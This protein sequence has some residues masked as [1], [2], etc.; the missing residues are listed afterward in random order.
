MTGESEKPKH[1]RGV[2]SICP[3]PERARAELLLAAGGRFSETAR[4]LGMSPDA[5]ERHW[6]KHVPPS[7][8]KALKPGAEALMARLE[9]SGQIAEESTGTLEHLKAVRA[10]L[11]Q[12]V[13]EA[14][15]RGHSIPATAAA[16]QY[17]KTCSVIAKLTGELAQSPLVASTHYHVHFTEAPEFQA[18]MKDLAKALAPYPEARRA[19]FEQFSRLEQQPEERVIEMPALEHQHAPAAQHQ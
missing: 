13:I 7:H 12:L 11:W 17:V 3:H 9:L 18:L 4:K 15:G 5:L 2:C 1:R 14:R 6:K 10:V 16:G 8:R 19:V